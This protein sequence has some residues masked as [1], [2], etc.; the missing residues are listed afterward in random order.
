M[1]RLKGQ[2]LVTANVLSDTLDDLSDY[3]GPDDQ[4]AVGG[5]LER[6]GQIQI[7]DRY[8]ELIR[9]ARDAHQLYQGLLDAVGRRENFEHAAT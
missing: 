1:R 4:E 9:L 6:L 7:P 5:I 3:L 8:G 2:A